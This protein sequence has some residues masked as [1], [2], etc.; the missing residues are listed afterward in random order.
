VRSNVFDVVPEG[1]ETD[2]PGYGA[3]T[4]RV[5]PLVGGEAMGMSVYELPPGQSICPYHY[6]LAEEE[7]LVV[8]AGSATVR[9]PEGDQVL[10]PWDAV[11]FTTG[12]DGAHKVTNGRFLEFVP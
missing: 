6:E 7:W 4:T 10:G 1:D 9:T 5:G 12:E 2:P 3:R 8:L 11:C